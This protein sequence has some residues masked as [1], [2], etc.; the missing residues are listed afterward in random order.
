VFENRVLRRM[1]GPKRD[2]VIGRWRKL[3][4]E[5]LRN[6]YSSPCIMRMIKSRRMRWTG[7][8]VRMGKVGMHIGYWWES[9]KE[10]DHQE[11]LDMGGENNTRIKMDLRE[12]GWGGMDWIDLA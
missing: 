2:E 10:R 12:I 9:Q 7:H 4:N 5:E 8:V 1:S 6:L 3:H 11:D